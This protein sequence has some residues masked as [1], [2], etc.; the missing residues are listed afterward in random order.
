M[1]FKAIAA[2]SRRADAF[3]ALRARSRAMPCSIAWLSRYAIFHLRRRSTAAATRPGP[4][5][6]PSL[7]PGP[8][9]CVSALPP[10]SCAAMLR[11]S[12]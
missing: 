5:P 10:S 7:G 6:G 3:A 11:D 2:S 8:G 1:E 12:A 9:P 4:T